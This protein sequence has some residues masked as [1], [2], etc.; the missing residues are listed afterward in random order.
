MTLLLAQLNLQNDYKQLLGS[1]LC[2]YLTFPSSPLFLRPSPDL[3]STHP[4]LIIRTLVLY[5]LLFRRESC[6]TLRA[7]SIRRDPTIASI[8]PERPTKYRKTAVP[9]HHWI[10]EERE[11]LTVLYK[12][13]E[14]LNSETAEI[15]N[16]FTRKCL[17]EKGSQYDLT[18]T[19]IIAQVNNLRNSDR[20]RN[21]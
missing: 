15:F 5:L 10:G 7:S 21:F 1:L 16:S 14:L 19:A 12:F 9:K 17:A 3:T 20:G 11:F 4:L 6:P 2:Y 8:K 18:A 13:Y